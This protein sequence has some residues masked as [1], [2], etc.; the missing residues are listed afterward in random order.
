MIQ[1]IIPS[2]GEALPVTALGTRQTFDVEKRKYFPV[3]QQ[4]FT[5]LYNARGSQEVL[6]MNQVIWR[7]LFENYQLKRLRKKWWI[8]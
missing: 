4:V 3:L 6:P 2:S 1:G 7:R 5:R 8:I